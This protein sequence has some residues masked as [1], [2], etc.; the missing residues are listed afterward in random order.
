MAA[1]YSRVYMC[2]I[3]LINLQLMSIWV[4]FISYKHGVKGNYIKSRFHFTWIYFHR[5]NGWVTCRPISGMWGISTLSST[6]LVL[7]YIPTS[8][9]LGYILP[10][11]SDQHLLFF[12]FCML[13][14][15]SK[16]KWNFIV[17]S[18]CISLMP[19][20]PQHFFI[21]LLVI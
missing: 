13:A 9:A 21:G 3:F 5:C 14:I 16:V 19:R 6:V 12:Y 2:H 18:I 11:H 10:L 17:V 8:S 7:V 4:G 15:L 1:L 20:K